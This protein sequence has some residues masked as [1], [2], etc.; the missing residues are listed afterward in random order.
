[1]GEKKGERWTEGAWTVSEQDGQAERM[2]G[3]RRGV[4]WGE[5]EGCGD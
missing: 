2:Y 3:C 4:G 5:G 1:M